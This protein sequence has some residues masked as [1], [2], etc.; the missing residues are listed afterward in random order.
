MNNFLYIFYQV[1][2]LKAQYRGGVVSVDEEEV[3]DYAW[4]TREEMKD[5]VPPDYY[6][7][8][9]PTLLDWPTLTDLYTLISRVYSLHGLAT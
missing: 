5:Y 9:A 8:I 2:F 3:V 1:F 6:T 7:A 4:V